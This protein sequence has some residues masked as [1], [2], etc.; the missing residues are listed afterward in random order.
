MDEPTIVYV[1]TGSEDMPLPDQL[2]ARMTAENFEVREIDLVVNDVPEDADILFIT[3][4]L[5]DWT[6]YKADRIRVFFD[7]GG[8]AFLAFHSTGKDFPNMNEVLAGYGVA[9]GEY[10]I[11]EYSMTHMFNN[12]PLFILPTLRPHQITEP[13][14]ARSQ[15]ILMSSTT[16]FDMLPDRRTSTEITE[17]LRTSSFS[18]GMFGETDEES[19]PDIVTGP[20]SV[21]IAITDSV[22]VEQMITTR[23]VMVGSP[24]MLENTHNAAIGGGNFDFVINSLNWLHERPSTVWIPPF[25]FMA[26][27]IPMVMSSAQQHGLAVTAIAGVPLLCVV[28]GLFVWFK[29]RFS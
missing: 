12:N 8:R 2:V 1:V 27:Q 22:F 19:E 24:W 7:R 23:L 4:P 29:R 10:I 28:I 6:H 25:V 18:M 17:L 11:L 5:R 15:R 9:I 13:L 20:F 26:G 16:G 14:H 3:Q 21:A